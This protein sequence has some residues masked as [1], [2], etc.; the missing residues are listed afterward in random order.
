M[1]LCPRAPSKHRVAQTRWRQGFLK[2]QMLLYLPKVLAWG[3]FCWPSQRMAVGVPAQS[4]KGETVQPCCGGLGAGFPPGA[5]V[6]F[7]PSG[8]QGGQW[9]PALP[10][11]EGT[12]SFGVPRKNCRT[13]SARSARQKSRSRTWAMTSLNCRG[14]E[15]W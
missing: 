3:W 5:L 2:S 8:S 12:F 7:P 1:T 14:R 11:Q 9:V 15:G 10:S 6:G 4:S 13:R